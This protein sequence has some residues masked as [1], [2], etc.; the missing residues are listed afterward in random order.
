MF[1]NKERYQKKC[2]RI[3]FNVSSLSW[4]KRSYIKKSLLIIIF[5]VNVY[6]ESEFLGHVVPRD[7]N[8]LQGTQRKTASVNISVRVKALGPAR[9]Q[10]E[11]GF[12]LYGAVGFRIIT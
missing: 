4:V 3:F 11:R 10:L 7:H 8:S 12:T 6:R 2:C 5:A 1:F 9:R